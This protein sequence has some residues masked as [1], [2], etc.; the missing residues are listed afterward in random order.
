ME[1]LEEGQEAEG[2]REFVRNRVRHCVLSILH[3]V[4]VRGAETERLENAQYRLEWLLSVV[5][6]YYQ[7]G[8]I[9]RDTINLL[10][11]ALVNLTSACGTT[12]TNVQT[13]AIFTGNPGRPRFNIPEEQLSFLV[14]RR[15][16]ASQMAALLG[17]SKR[18]VERRLRDIGLSIRGTYTNLTE[19][20][21]DST[22]EQILT[23]LPN[24][25]YKRMTGYLLARGVRVQQRKIRESMRRVDPQ[26]TLIRALEI[27]VIHR[28]S[29]SVP[30]PLALW[31][32]D[33][34]HKLIR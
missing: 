15:F 13:E 25:G 28:R 4:E 14:D 18:T 20:E 27:N 29:Y 16:T 33:G 24:T 19:E 34:N 26:G 11:E 32:I 2:G 17:V 3:Q 21:L 10:G 22:V 7:C 6:R 23:S 31:H 12:D 5:T 30:S 1:E 9:E 8:F